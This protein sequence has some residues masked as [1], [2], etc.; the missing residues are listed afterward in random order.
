MTVESFDAL[1][2]DGRA[3]MQGNLDIYAQ[4]LSTLDTFGLGFE[5]RPFQPENK[6]L[7]KRVPRCVP[8]VKKPP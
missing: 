2:E 8:S 7:A 4:L 6:T 5:M 1:I 3:T